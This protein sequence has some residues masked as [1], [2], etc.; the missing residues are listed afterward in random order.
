MSE[1]NDNHPV[2]M[3][4]EPVLPVKDVHETVLYWHDVLGFPVK[5][6][7]GEPANHGGV[8]W[9]GVYV[10]FT[11]DPELAVASKGN[12]IWIRVRQLALL[13]EIH[14]KRN[15][16]IVQGLV[17]RPWG[18]AEYT[19]KDIN[20]YYIIFAGAPISDNKKSNEAMPATVR[21]T[22]RIPTAEE[23][24]NLVSAVGWRKYTSDV[25]VE[26]ILSAPL[27]S[28][29]AEDGES[30]TVIGCALLLGDGVSFYYVK[31]VMVNPEW[32]HKQV[33]TSMLRRLT[34]WLDD[35]APENAFVTLIT[36]ENLAPFYQQF[37]FSPVFGMHR[38]IQPNHKNKS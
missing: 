33:G 1:T 22:E 3:H 24:L 30:R 18:M 6:T 36:P 4:A 14:Q 23:Y 31:D 15:A 20:G 19:V 11:L 12:C 8:S 29:V 34:D 26:K 27:F 13:H 16:E 10:Q 37:D 7:W 17:N 21:I 35:N 28:V 32:Q 5:W 9:Q 25:L 2:L 38:S